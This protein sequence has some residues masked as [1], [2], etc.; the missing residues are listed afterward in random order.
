ML[1]KN[2]CVVRRRSKKRQEKRG[3]G[4]KKKA[5]KQRKPLL[6][7]S[8]RSCPVAFPHASRYRPH[9]HPH[10]QAQRRAAAVGNAGPWVLAPL[11]PAWCVSG[12]ASLFPAAVII[13]IIINPAAL[14]NVGRQQP[15]YVVAPSSMCVP[16]SQASLRGQGTSCRCRGERAACM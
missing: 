6:P 11:P 12:A 10:T 3:V 15:W 4:G 5:K 2:E 8:L 16:P 14:P 13:F 9:T 7:L 1:Y